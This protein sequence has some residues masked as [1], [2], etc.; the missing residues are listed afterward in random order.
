MLAWSG[1]VSCNTQLPV[2][3]VRTSIDRSSCSYQLHPH[4]T[5][6]DEL[7]Q[8]RSEHTMSGRSQSVVSNRYTKRNERYNSCTMTFKGTYTTNRIR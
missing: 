8:E 5:S 6:L 2:A 7:M 4:G 3:V 1:I